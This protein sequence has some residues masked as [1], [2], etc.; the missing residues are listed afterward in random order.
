MLAEV[1]VYVVTT[2]NDTIYELES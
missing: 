2:T 1:S